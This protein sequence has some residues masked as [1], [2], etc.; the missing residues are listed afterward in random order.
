MA[1][2]GLRIRDESGGIRVLTMAEPARRNALSDDMRGALRDALQAAHDD[3]SVRALVLTGS[4]GCFCAGGDIKAMGQPIPIALK[5][6]DIVHDIVRLIALGPKP[7][8]AAVDGAAYGG[9]MSLALC[10]DLVVAAE[11][12]RFC[13]SFARVGLVPDMGIMWSLPRRV[14][15]ARA[16][17]ILLDSRERAGAEAVET[18]MADILTDGD[19]VA[20]AIDAAHALMP[21]A[22]LPAAHLRPI[23]ARHQGDLESVLR[24]ERAAQATLFAT[25]DHDEA[26]RAFLEKR[27]PEFSGV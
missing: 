22:P 13:A 14:G 2:E 4:G 16:Q 17:Q 25:Q 20:R 1:F 10:C 11:S 19:P 3:A 26:R 7:V 12:A 9:G 6:L 27:P 18:G 21:A 15:A 5:R 8:V 24:D 23:L